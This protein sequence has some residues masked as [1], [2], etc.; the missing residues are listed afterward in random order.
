M[1][2]KIFITTQDILDLSL[3]IV[4]QYWQQLALDVGTYSASD[5]NAGGPKGQAIKELIKEDFTRFFAITI[6]SFQF[7]YILELRSTIRH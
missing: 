3:T 4:F 1:N 2:N 5:I 6:G 7:C